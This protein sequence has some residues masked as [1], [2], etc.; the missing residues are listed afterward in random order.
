MDDSRLRINRLTRALYVSG[1]VNILLIAFLIYWIWREQPPAPYFENKPAT[2]SEKQKPL[3]LSQTNGQII[4][5]M[6]YMTFDQLI[7]QLNNNELVDNGYARKD[8]A[9]ATLVAVH[10]LDLDR[11]IQGLSAPEQQRRLVYG[12][13]KDGSAAEIVVYPSLSNEHFKAIIAFSKT[14][15]WPLTTK[16]LFSLIKEQYTKKEPIDPSLM[17][18][19]VLSPEFRNVE[20]LFTRAGKPIDQNALIALISEGDWKSLSRFSEQQKG[21]QDLS[22]ARRQQ[23]LVDYLDQGSSAAAYLMLSTDPEFAQR[24]LD[25]QRV[26][27]LLKLLSTHTTA[28]K[29]Y[30]LAQLA[31]PRSD[32]V[33]RLAAKRLYEYAGEIPPEKFNHRVALEKF[34][35]KSVSLPLAIQAT[36]PPVK[37]KPVP[38]TVPARVT[39]PKKPVAAT[40]KP[41][42]VGKPNSMTYVVREGDTLLVISRRFKVEVEAIRKKNNL[43]SDSLKPG[44]LIQIP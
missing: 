1:T 34:L 25:D 4:R 36:P 14:E 9:L 16:G 42:A 23:F 35:P 24:K 39:Q 38:A 31:S 44:T 26:L 30:A 27:L 2:K 3:A 10:E 18:T 43:R 19:F 32:A 12:K 7:D 22:E 6:R 13:F 21:I 28:A 5:Q 20:M 40:T 8:L 29:N 41:T 17:D 11:A 33:L 15:K 37:S